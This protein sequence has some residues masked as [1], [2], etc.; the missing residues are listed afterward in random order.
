[1]ILAEFCLHCYKLK[2]MPSMSLTLYKLPK[3]IEGA[4]IIN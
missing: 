3:L 2:K 1:M 4:V